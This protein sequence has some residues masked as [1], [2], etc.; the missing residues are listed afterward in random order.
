MIKNLPANAGDMGS[1]PG[2]GR[3]PAEGNDYPIQH[4][5]LGNPMDRGGWW[6]TVHELDK[7]AGHNIA[8]KQQQKHGAEEFSIRAPQGSTEAA[9]RRGYSFGN[10]YLKSLEKQQH[11][12]S[13]STT[14]NF[15]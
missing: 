13:S 5:H 3:S 11:H 15:S 6:A 8:T 14:S 4:S 9:K 12:S 7:R 1:I 2:L 10:C